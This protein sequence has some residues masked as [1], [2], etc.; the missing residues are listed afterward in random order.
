MDIIQ[1]NDNRIVRALRF[2][3]NKFSFDAHESAQIAPY[4]DDSCPVSGLKGVKSKTST[5]SIHVILGY[6][7]RNPKAQTGEKRLYATDK[8][9]NFVCSVWFK[10]DGSIEFNNDPDETTPANFGVKYNELKTQF[11]QLKSDFGTLLTKYNTH[12]HAVATAGNATAQTGTAAAT[13]NTTTA[14]SADITQC[15]NSKIKT[16]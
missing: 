3:K 10:N 4:G 1:V 13:T 11:E 7:G 9:G 6:F 14:N 16:T 2:I 12:T 8:D 15:K 5:D